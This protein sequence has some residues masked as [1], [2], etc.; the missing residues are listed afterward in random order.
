MTDCGPE[1]AGAAGMAAAADRGAEHVASLPDDPLRSTHMSATPASS[2]APEE[3]QSAPAVAFTSTSGD[4]VNLAVP[5]EEAAMSEALDTHLTQREDA[6]VL[7][8][9]AAAAAAASDLSANEPAFAASGGSIAEPLEK[10]DESESAEEAE[11]EEEEEAFLFPEEEEDEEAADA[12]RQAEF[13]RAMAA[14]AEE[15]A[16]GAV[17]HSPFVVSEDHAAVTIS[18]PAAIAMAGASSASEA[19]TLAAATAPLQGA[20]AGVAMDTNSEENLRPAVDGSSSHTASTQAGSDG[21]TGITME[22]SA[23]LV[24]EPSRSHSQSVPAHRDHAEQPSEQIQLHPIRVSVVPSSTA[25]EAQLLPAAS[26]PSSSGVVSLAEAEEGK[27][28]ER[29]HQ[30]HPAGEAAAAAAVDDS[31]RVVLVQEGNSTM[32]CDPEGA[33]A[34]APDRGTEHISLSNDSLPDPYV[35]CLHCGQGS[36][37]PCRICLSQ[38]WCCGYQ[39]RRPSGSQDGRTHRRTSLSAGWRRCPSQSADRFIST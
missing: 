5:Q 21:M 35:C 13:D 7:A 29:V 9:A 6:S 25:E 24:S 39:P 34:A 16:G 30:N 14:F 23:L 8:A 3:T 11:C 36:V 20:R 26:A 37:P 10:D 27:D 19:A 18:V 1:G 15:A 32:D 2:S 17:P 4:V 33:G 28:D 31:S 12:R 38:R 22:T